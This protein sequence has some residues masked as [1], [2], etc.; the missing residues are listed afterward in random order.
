MKLETWTARLG[1]CLLIRA[2]TGTRAGLARIMQT[3]SYGPSQPVEGFSRIPRT[4]EA[5]NLRDYK[6]GS[7]SKS[8]L[9]ESRQ[10]SA[11]ETMADN[12]HAAEGRSR[13]VSKIEGNRGATWGGARNRKDRVTTALSQR[14]TENLLRAMAVAE[15]RGTPLNRHWTVN[16]GWAGIE[17]KDGAAFVGALLRHANRYARRRGGAFAAVWVREVGLRNGPHVHIAFHWPRGWKLGYLTRRWIKRAGGRYSKRVSK[18]RPIGLGNNCPWTSR[19]LYRDNLE[20]L[21][22]YITK[23]GDS[24]AA[25]ELGLELLKPGGAIIGKRCGRTQNLGWPDQTSA[26]G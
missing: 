2:E 11:D 12:P 10:L 6:K 13:R 8:L 26:S 23:S 25:A 7:G 24:A 15:L 18:V 9:P 1:A 3:I 20:K 5:E 19:E 4:Q 21:G 22:N 17:D 14:Q 16:Y